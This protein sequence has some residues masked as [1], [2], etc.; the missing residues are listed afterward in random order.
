MYIMLRIIRI[1]ETSA[2]YFLT[3]DTS[4]E[5]ISKGLE[6][7]RRG[8][9][10]LENEGR[11]AQAGSLAFKMISLG[12]KLDVV[13]TE[14]IEMGRTCL[15]MFVMTSNV[16]M[17]GSCLIILTLVL[18]RH[19]ENTAL[20]DARKLFNENIANIDTDVQ[21]VMKKI[22]K[23]LEDGDFSKI[24]EIHSAYAQIKEGR[25]T[26][27]AV[28]S[29]ML[30]ELEP[31]NDS[32]TQDN[33]LSEKEKTLPDPLHSNHRV[34]VVSIPKVVMAAAGTAVAASAF[35]SAKIIKKDLK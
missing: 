12:L 6:L 1:L 23:T 8:V 32:L 26:L 3:K 35:G 2:N 15:K 30:V 34:P 18:V 10:I 13:G 29:L 4:A 20:E 25:N 9:H 7:L 19:F 22:L 21:D 16:K 24:D 28:K 17:T 5:K 11:P 33:Q 14:M 31:E 27:G